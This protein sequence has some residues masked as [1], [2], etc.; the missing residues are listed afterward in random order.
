MPDFHLPER[1]ATLIF[2]DGDLTGL[3]LEVR[4]SL[5]FDALF[6]LQALSTEARDAASLDKLQELLHYFAEIALVGWNL[7]NGSG[8]VKLTPAALTAHLD[9]GNAGALLSRYFEAVGGVP[10]PLAP[11]SAS[12]VTSA[13]RRAS[14]NRK[15]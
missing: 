10:G 9:A 1:I 13:K 14:S 11:P 4:L 3:E 6:K 8:P 12:G 7:S 2:E 5:P 15:S